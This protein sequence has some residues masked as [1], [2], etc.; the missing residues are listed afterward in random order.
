MPIK[1]KKKSTSRPFISFPCTGRPLNSLCSTL[2]VDGHVSLATSALSI[3]PKRQDLEGGSFLFS[4]LEFS[5]R[6]FLTKQRG[7]QV[8]EVPHLM[9]QQSS[10]EFGSVKIPGHSLSSSALGCLLEKQVHW[11]LIHIP[12][13]APV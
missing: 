5:P 13:N 6:H 4:W 9:K 8:W 2:G 7:K 3:K 12:D 10:V 11:D 1:I